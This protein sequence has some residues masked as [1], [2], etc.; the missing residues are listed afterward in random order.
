MNKF[1]K[2]NNDL[3]KELLNKNIENKKEKELINSKLND[4]INEKLKLI[5]ENKKLDYSFIEMKEELNKKKEMQIC[6]N[7]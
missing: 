4:E 2:Q 3:E 7:T 6:I 5:K 1:Q